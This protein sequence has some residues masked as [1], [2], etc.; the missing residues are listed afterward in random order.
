MTKGIVCSIDFSESSKD[1]L[2]WAGSLAKM[3]NTHLTVLYTYRLLHSYNGEAP[4]IKKNIEQNANNNFV[5]FEKE[6]LAGQGIE[7]D[8]KIEV[9]FVSN[10]V[11]DHAKRNGISMVVMGSKMNS[12]NKESF[13]E[14]AQSLHVPLVIVPQ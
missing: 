6:L 7:Y 10:R 3:L 12:M 2:K 4:E 5:L 9:G 11:H 13:D 8:F 1:V 14:L